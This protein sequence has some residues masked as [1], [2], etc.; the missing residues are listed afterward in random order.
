LTSYDPDA[1]SPWDLR[2]VVHPHR[3]AGLAPAEAGRHQDLGDLRS[4]KDRKS[5]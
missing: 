2:R 3:R 1:K 4:K 5:P